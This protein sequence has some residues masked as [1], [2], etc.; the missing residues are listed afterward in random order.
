MEGSMNVKQNTEW[1]ILTPDG[2]KDFN[3]ISKT[4]KKLQKIY[5]QGHDPIW[6]SKKH[7][8]YVGGRKTRVSDLKKSGYI[9][10][11]EGPKRYRKTTV[12][13]KQHAYDIIE[14]KQENHQYL[15]NGC[16]TT[17]NCDEFA[18][19]EPNIAEDFWTS[20]SPTLST[21]GSCI[22]ASTP[23]GDDNKFAELWRGANLNNNGFVPFFVQW[24][25]VPGRDETYK[26]QEIGKIGLQKWEQEYECL[27]GDSLVNL[28]ID[29]KERIV[30]I[31]K[32]HQLSA[33]NHHN[34][35]HKNTLDYKIKTPNGWESFA[36]VAL[37][38]TKPVKVL[39]FDD[40][41][42]ISG[43]DNH[44]LFTS[45][46]V[47]I[48]LKD[49]AIGTTLR[50]KSNKTVVNISNG[51][52]EKVY[53]VIETESH[54]FYANDILSHNCKFI[55][56]D[57]LLFS[58]TYITN[59]Y[60]DTKAEPDARDIT[61]FDKITPGMSY[62][63][64]IDPASGTGSDYTVMIVYSFPELNQIA[65]FRSNTT[66]T[67]LVY[68]TFKHILRTIQAGGAENCYWSFE[69]NGIGEGLI[70]MYESDEKPIEFGDL[71]S[72]PGK[73]RIGFFTGKNKTNVCLL[74]KQI[75]ESGKMT[76]KS[77]TVISEMKNFVRR[78]GSFSAR[79]GSNDDT[80]SAH[81]I[82]VRMLQ[83]LVQYEE[84]AYDVVFQHKEGEDI[85]NDD[86]YDDYEPPLP[87]FGNN[88]GHDINFDQFFTDGW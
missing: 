20:I 18:F 3:G 46:N 24:D 88:G 11:V 28:L 71:I 8:F 58:S 63:I 67:P 32:L 49:V 82:L 37:M 25:T 29:N 62:V 75:F 10:S 5:I 68:N 81:L 31:E 70:S 51:E 21:G 15:V 43:T 60:C 55:S 83:E 41:T 73:R 86:D 27:R 17:K 42:N 56:S 57:P 87:V 65:Q 52:I 1:E 6:A 74:F 4:Y 54:T 38:G 36:G 80:I 59:Y 30:T 48:L 85:F 78:S 84:R 13:E 79:T 44:I 39:T 53:D 77:P 23:N 72:E 45:D 34:Y 19:V 64:A 16:F 12:F 61:W 40:G 50:G 33:V 35:L 26:Q 76:I 9:D 7:Y 69:N 2:F 14:V 66:S 22:I 47:E